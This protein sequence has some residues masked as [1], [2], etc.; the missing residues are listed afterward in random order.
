MTSLPP[1]L[2]AWLLVPMMTSL[3]AGASIS[4]SF[5]YASSCFFSR[6]GGHCS[7]E[8]SRLTTLAAKAMQLVSPH[9][10][11]LVLGSNMY[12]SI[13]LSSFIPF[14]ISLSVTFHSSLYLHSDPVSYLL[15]T[16]LACAHQLLH[17]LL[18]SPNSGWMHHHEQIYPS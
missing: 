16:S 15:R 8:I 7:I 4:C 1:T 5:S 2:T 17:G 12:T 9:S 3:T 10:L 18:H 14:L 6:S 13:G 11:Q